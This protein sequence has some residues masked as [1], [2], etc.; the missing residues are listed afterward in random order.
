MHSSSRDWI[1]LQELLA[2]YSAPVLTVF[3]PQT[4][5]QLRGAVIRLR[6]YG[7]QALARFRMKS[8]LS[9]VLA[10][11]VVVITGSGMA[12]MNNAC[13]SS[14]HTWCAPVSDI[15]HHARTMHG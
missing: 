8:P 15:R 4:F 12:L 10:A 13:K 9:F 1:R 6:D 11:V 14:K 2:T 7:G 3:T 5:P